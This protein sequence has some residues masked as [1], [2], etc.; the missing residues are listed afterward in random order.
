MMGDGRLRLLIRPGAESPVTQWFLNK[1]LSDM[2]KKKSRGVFGSIGD[3]V[4]NLVD[5]GSVAATGSQLG[6]LELAAE[7]EIAP[8]PASSK[9]KKK[10]TARKKK[11]AVAKS[12][13]KAVVK[14]KKKA[15]AKKKKT[16]KQ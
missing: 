7:E 3:A 1:G 16:K 2:A 6:V 14:A 12:K 11:K 15:K 8:T 9:K 10:K 5:A 13:K 4:S